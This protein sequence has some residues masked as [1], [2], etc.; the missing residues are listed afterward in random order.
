MRSSQEK[1]QVSL[2]PPDAAGLLH[3]VREN[4][5][6]LG[7]L[8]HRYEVGLLEVQ[9]ERQ[10]LRNPS[11][12]AGYLGPE[13]AD[14]AQEQLRMVLLGTRNR[15]MGVELVYQGGINATTIR[16]AG[17]F[18]QAVARAAAAVILVHNDACA[19][20]LGFA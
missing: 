16:I 11:D 9:P 3:L 13:L 4:L 12:V 15:V 14:L 1:Q 8:A 17:C 10:Q 2:L 6:L 18:R 19:A 5:R 20:G 7:H